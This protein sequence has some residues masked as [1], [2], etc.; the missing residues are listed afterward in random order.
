[1]IER[2]VRNPTLEAS[3]RIAKALKIA[4]PRLIEEAQQQRRNG[5]E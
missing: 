1:M 2:G 4:L 5:E 3:A